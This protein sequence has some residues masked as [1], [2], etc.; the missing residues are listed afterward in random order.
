MYL[1]TDALSTESFCSVAIYG[2]FEPLEKLNLQRR[3]AKLHAWLD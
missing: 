3:V 1:L 2:M